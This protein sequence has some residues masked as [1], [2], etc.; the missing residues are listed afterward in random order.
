M[1]VPEADHEQYV[2]RAIALAREAG[3]RGDG[4]YG[5][6][7]VVDDEVVMEETNRER[8]DGDIALHPELTL[9]R[10]AARELP[11]DE[12]DRA[13]LYTSTEPC[14]MCAGGIAIAGLGG[15]VYSVSGA[16]AAERFGGA[17]GIPCDE[18]FDRRGA[19]VPVVGGVAEDAGLAVHEEHR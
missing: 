7:L 19:D 14:P 8:T 6:V 10:R 17:P 16:L 4:A 15:V 12:R 13:V 5:S 18:V 11:A 3:E 2:E 9:A 1:S